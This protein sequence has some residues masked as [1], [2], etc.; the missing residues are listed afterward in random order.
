[1]SERTTTGDD[2]IVQTFHDYVNM[3][4]KALEAWLETSESQE[5]G[6]KSAPDSESTGHESGRTIVRLL[7]KKTRRVR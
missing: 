5:V 4:S 6:Q 7:H 1:M 3:T 2:E